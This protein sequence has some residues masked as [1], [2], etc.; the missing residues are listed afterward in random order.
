MG[1]NSY[2]IHQNHSR[3]RAGRDRPRREGQTLMK[4]PNEQF[5]PHPF[6]RLLPMM[7][8]PEYQALKADLAANGLREPIA[9]RHGLAQARR[10]AV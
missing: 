3:A 4:K 6:A 9:L 5:A 2:Q 1:P 7:S 8:E 10:S